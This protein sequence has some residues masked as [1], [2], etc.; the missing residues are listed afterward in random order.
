MCDMLEIEVTSLKQEKH[1]N[2]YGGSFYDEELGCNICLTP[3]YIVD[4]EYKIVSNIQHC[5]KVT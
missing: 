5:E 2:T 3:L 4:M 1:I